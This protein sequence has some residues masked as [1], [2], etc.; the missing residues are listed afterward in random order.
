MDAIGQLN[1][2]RGQV[3][4]AFRTPFPRP[5]EREFPEDGKNST[6]GMDW[7]GFKQEEMSP[8]DQNSL[9]QAIS[10]AQVEKTGPGAKT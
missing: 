1:R 9:S 5:V 6:C 4:L 10:I 2:Q 8:L 3:R 7:F